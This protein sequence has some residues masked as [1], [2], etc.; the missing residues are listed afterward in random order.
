[1]KKAKA[2]THVP[3]GVAVGKNAFAYQMENQIY[4]VDPDKE[5]SKGSF[6]MASTDSRT[7]HL[8]EV[9]NVDGKQYLMREGNLVSSAKAKVY[10]TVAANLTLYH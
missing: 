3:P 4:F 10:G 8:Y 6:V 7:V 9:V 2:Q 1:M 5:A